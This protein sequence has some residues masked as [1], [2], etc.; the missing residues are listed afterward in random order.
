MDTIVAWVVS[1]GQDISVSTAAV[2]MAVAVYRE[3]IVPGWK[4][5]RLQSKC[6]AMESE[7]RASD[8]QLVRLVGAV[9]RLEQSLDRRKESSHA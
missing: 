5:R 7:L 2:L 8:D 4:F 1:N 9:E 6:D 3:S